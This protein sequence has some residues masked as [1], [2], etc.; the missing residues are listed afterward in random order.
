[1]TNRINSLDHEA[2][3]EILKQTKEIMAQYGKA[4]VLVDLST[5][6]K[7]L[8]FKTRLNVSEFIKEKPNINKIAILG[9]AITIRVGANI[10]MIASA[11]KNVKFF[12]NE[13]EA[14]QWLKS[15]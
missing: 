6:K 5:L 10:I 9:A 1:M 2:M 13:K 12:K 4:N 7:N 3:I 15:N 11:K 8:L 14:F